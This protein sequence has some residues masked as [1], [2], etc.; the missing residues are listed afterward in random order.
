MEENLDPY[1]VSK[2]LDQDGPPTLKI[3]NSPWAKFKYYY[4][5]IMIGVSVQNNGKFLET[6]QIRKLNE[7]VR[8]ALRKQIFETGAVTIPKNLSVFY[9]S[10]IC[11][12]S[13][14]HASLKYF[15]FLRGF[16][17]EK[18]A[19][20]A[21]QLVFDKIKKIQMKQY[22]CIVKMLYIGSYENKRHVMV[23]PYGF[24]G[25]ESTPLEDI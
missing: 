22:L 5:G 17:Q 6:L 12:N 4:S 20:D 9:N 25:K 18:E 2:R 13:L 3:S 16:A 15:V 24:Y 23:I 7:K 8:R 14:G 1:N 10:Y 21:A 11:T 19:A